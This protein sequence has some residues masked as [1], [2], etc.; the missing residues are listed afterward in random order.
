M[1]VLTWLDWIHLRAPRGSRTYR[2]PRPPHWSNAFADTTLPRAPSRRAFCAAPSRSTAPCARH[3]LFHSPIA[4]P[5]PVRCIRFSIPP[6]LHRAL[7]AAFAFPFPPRASLHS[8]PCVICGCVC[9]CVC[10]CVVGGVNIQ[11]P[12]CH[13]V[14]TG[15]CR[16]RAPTGPLTPRRSQRCGRSASGCCRAC[17]TRRCSGRTGVRAIFEFDVV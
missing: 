15:G 6:P 12:H 11:H 13:Y 7:C 5:H 8:H 14:L 9:V 10:V 1:C 16:R 4:P 3:S 2:S 17:A